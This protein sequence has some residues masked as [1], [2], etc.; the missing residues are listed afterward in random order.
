MCGWMC[1]GGCVCVM[2]SM[3]RVYAYARRMYIHTLETLQERR[4][5]K[6]EDRGRV[7]RKRDSD[8]ERA[9]REK[10]GKRRARERER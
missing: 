10:D 4:R 8:R 1:V 5:V 6:E 2:R 3:T 7:L 9:R